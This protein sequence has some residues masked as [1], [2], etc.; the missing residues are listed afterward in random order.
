VNQIVQIDN[1]LHP[2]ACDLL[3][4]S[5]DDIGWKDPEQISQDRKDYVA[6]VKRHKE[7][8][9]NHDKRINEHSKMLQVTLR[10][11]RV[12]NMVVQPKRMRYFQ[13]NRY[14][15]GEEYGWHSDAAFMHDMRTDFTAVIG[16]TDGYKGGDHLVMDGNE[17]VRYVIKKG[18]ALIYPSGVIHKVEP[19]VE[20]RRVAAVCWIESIFSSAVDRALV[21]E[22]WQ[23]S[24][25][26]KKAD[27]PFGPMTQL[28]TSLYHNMC[29]RLS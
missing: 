18:Q 4:Q 29:R 6:K 14:E 22:M 21:T 8:R 17:P 26:V 5:L 19:I 10:K 23:L 9:P 1:L 15:G 11:S 28:A 12:F 27:K 3:V 24:E 13:F 20:G 2:M 25:L 7:L 16:L